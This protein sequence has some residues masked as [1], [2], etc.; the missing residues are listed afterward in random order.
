[1]AGV[2]GAASIPFIGCVSLLACMVL[3]IL[4]FAAPF[5]AYSPTADIG[6]WRR[7]NCI[8]ENGVSGCYRTDHMWYFYTEWLDAVRAMEALAIIFW[9]IPLVILPVYIYVSLGLY[10]MCTMMTMSVF[11]ILGCVCNLIGIII[12]GAKI[13]ENSDWKTGWCL[14]LC[15]IACGLGIAAFV[16]F[17]IACCKKPQFDP[18]TYYISGL[19]VGP[20]DEQIYVIENSES[21]KNGSINGHGNHALVIDDN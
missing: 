16:L 3:Q 13:G 19:F 21:E 15:V 12:F 20:E 6:L 1:M 11:T 2:L 8:D 18:D 9:A 5:W 4:A 14:V 17:L 7:T 10:Y